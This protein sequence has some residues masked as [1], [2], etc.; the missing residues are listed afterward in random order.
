M[1]SSAGLC[2]GL[3]LAIA[4]AAVRGE[5]WTSSDGVVKVTVPDSGFVRVENPPPSFLVLWISADETIRLGVAQMPYPAGQR[6]NRANFE[7]GI[8]GAGAEITASSSSRQNGHEVWVV[9]T[10]SSTGGVKNNG[11]QSIIR[12]DGS[13]YQIVAITAADANID[14]AIVQQY[15]QSLQVSGPVHA[16]GVGG[17]TSGRGISLKKLTSDEAIEKLFGVLGSITGLIVMVLL[18]LW[19]LSRVTGIKPPRTPQSPLN[20][21]LPR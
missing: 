2:C 3:S 17:T 21:F 11:T 14:Q 15:L 18:G 16:G 5:E 6:L 13:I 12:V 19:A 9:S 10:T 8:A 1:I 20:D 4:T 7:Q